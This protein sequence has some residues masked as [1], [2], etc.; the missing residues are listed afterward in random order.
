MTDAKV[1]RS[2]ER[3]GERSVVAVAI[4]ATGTLVYDLEIHREGAP[5]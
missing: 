1:E 5:Q 2:E 3:S 4:P